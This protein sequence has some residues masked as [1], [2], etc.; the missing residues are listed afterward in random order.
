MKLLLLLLLLLLLGYH[1]VT[2]SRVQHLTIEDA[3][4]LV[5]TRFWFCF[6]G[7]KGKVPFFLQE[8]VTCIWPH[9]AITGF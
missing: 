9:L 8:N 6:Q 4:I 3:D 1:H 7:Y 5:N 2:E